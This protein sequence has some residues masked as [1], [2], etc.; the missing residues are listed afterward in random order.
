MVVCHPLKLQGCYGKQHQQRQ[1]KV[2]SDHLFCISNII[3]HQQQNKSKKNNS[4][5][6]G[7]STNRSNILTEAVAGIAVAIAAAKVAVASAAAE[8]AVAAAAATQH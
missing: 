1:K 2:D 6:I 7:I 4:E 8:V 5:R 3:I